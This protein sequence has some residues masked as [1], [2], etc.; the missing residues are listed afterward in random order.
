MI[1]I[2]EI[3]GCLHSAHDPARRFFL[4]FKFFCDESHDSPQGVRLTGAPPLEPKSYIVGG[5]FG[6]QQAWEIVEKRWKRKNDLEGVPR[7]HA[8]HLNAGT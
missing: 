8:S 3:A 6:G 2:R 5:F 7:Y 1:S 4:I